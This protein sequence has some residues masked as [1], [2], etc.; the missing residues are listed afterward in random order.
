[1]F[2]CCA[3]DWITWPMCGDLRA[4]NVM[5]SKEALKKQASRGNWE[6]SLGGCSLSTSGTRRKRRKRRHSVHTAPSPKQSKAI[7]P[8]STAWLPL[9]RQQPCPIHT[10]THRCWSRQTCNAALNVTE[11]MTRV[12]LKL[13]WYMLSFT[14]SPNSLEYSS[15]TRIS[16][17]H[18]TLSVEGVTDTISDTEYCIYSSPLRVLLHLLPGV[19]EF[20]ALHRFKLA[21]FVKIDQVR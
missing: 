21:G 7:L 6:E 16:Q 9:P 15:C 3:C 20:D 2:W 19:S 17:L 8:C 4:S 18:F 5:I 11:L 10:H 14:T 13:P 1:M 12:A